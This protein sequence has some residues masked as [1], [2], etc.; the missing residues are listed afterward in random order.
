MAEKVKLPSSWEK[1]YK[2]M[3]CVP[4]VLEYV[5][6]LLDSSLLF[7]YQPYR[8]S[9]EQIYYEMFSRNLDIYGVNF[10]QMEAYFKACGFVGSNIS[11]DEI[12]S[13]ID[14]CYPVVATVKN[15]TESTAHEVLIVS[16]TDDNTYVAVNPEQGNYQSYTQ[17][18]FY[19]NTFYVLK[20]YK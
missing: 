6:N 4:T 10:G 18:D 3:N 7:D 1:Q 8:V 19:Y 14:G 17:D 2:N 11:I 20:Q 15:S 13:S 16:Y 12:K 5:A 9:F